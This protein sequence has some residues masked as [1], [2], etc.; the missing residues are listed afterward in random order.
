[1]PCQHELQKV[2][3]P[4]CRLLETAK[5]NRLEVVPRSSRATD[6]S[7]ADELKQ[8]V[9]CYDALTVPPAPP[10]ITASTGNSKRVACQEPPTTCMQS[11]TPLASYLLLLGGCVC[12]QHNKTGT[13]A[14]L[15]MLQGH[16]QAD[17]YCSRT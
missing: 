8:A 15:V 2:A 12:S 16:P 10:R 1:M 14:Y 11:S 13:V 17:A 7:P 5:S 4:M 9:L 6:I 3:Q